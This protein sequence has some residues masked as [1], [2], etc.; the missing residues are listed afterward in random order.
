MKQNRFE[1][2]ASTAENPDIPYPINVSEMGDLNFEQRISQFLNS[3]NFLNIVKEFPSAERATKLGMVIEYFIIH[4]D[5]FDLENFVQQLQANPAIKSMS[6]ANELI[7]ASIAHKLNIKNTEDSEA[8]FQYFNDKYE[9]NGYYF[10]GFNGSFRN[11]IQKNGLS[12]K[13]RHWNWTE[14]EKIIEIAKK[15]GQPMILGWADINSKERISLAA[16]AN[17]IYSYAYASP[18]WFAAFVSEGSHVSDEEDRKKAFYRRDY[19]TAKNNIEKLVA[20]L[21]S[22]KQ[23]DIEAKKAY[24]NITPQEKQAILDFFEKYWKIFA[25]EKSKLE[26]ALVKKSA[27][28]WGRSTP[29]SLADYKK[30]FTGNKITTVQD[31]IKTELIG[32][33]TF[34]HD[35]QI[36]HDIPPEAIKIIE[37]PSY[38]KVFPETSE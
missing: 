1:N 38:D 30:H 27:T 28:K 25:E 32:D 37:L 10:H 6:D 11:D 16:S 17:N 23:E 4:P 22:R 9:R 29:V 13:E 26:G 36:N 33:E 34:H 31:V 14:L 15:A 24:P 3:E 35:M 8:I 18:E 5:G 19:K 2:S 20:A 21:T 7:V 12:V